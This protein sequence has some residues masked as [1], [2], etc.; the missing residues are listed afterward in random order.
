MER[1]MRCN[2]SARRTILLVILGALFALI[3]P[4]VWAQDIT[5]DWQ[6]SLTQ[7]PSQ[8]R[9]A[10]HIE[11]PTHFGCDYTQVAYCYVATLDDIDL[12]LKNLPITPAFRG[13]RG[14]RY[15]TF[16]VSALGASYSGTVNF[17]AMTE[18]KGT[19]TQ[20]N[21]SVP[22]DFT[23][24][25][26]PMI[27]TQHLLSTDP[28]HVS[29]F[30]EGNDPVTP[31]MPIKAGDDWLK[32]IS[33]TIKNV[34]PKDIT[35]VEVDLTLLDTGNGTSQRPFL[36]GTDVKLGLLPEH[37]LYGHTKS[38]ER[39]R[40]Q[41]PG[42][43]LLVPPGKQLTVSFAS[44]YNEIKEY[45]EAAGYPMSTIQKVLLTYDIFFADGTKCHDGEYLRPDPAV[46]SRYLPI[47]FSEFKQYS[48]PN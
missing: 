38:G 14:H 37:D 12:G 30:K 21:D 25:D 42:P 26:G 1:S 27:F 4:A 24:P 18:I 2:C 11:G 48:P 23:R 3:P 5:G 31:G 33:F 9:L 8:F 29:D 36:G 17:P 16:D 44:Q 7:G 46:H 32:D 10:L 6:A 47:S 40:P 19:W 15:L 45:V 13:P 20:D 28:I 35:R 22:L 39:P 34:S 41:D 43:P